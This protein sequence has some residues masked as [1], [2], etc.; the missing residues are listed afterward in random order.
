MGEWRNKSAIII[1]W[2]Y[3]M[4][5]VS[6]IPPGE[7]SPT[8]FVWETGWALGEGLN[9]TITA[10]AGNKTPVIH[11]LANGYWYPLLDKRK[12]LPYQT[13]SVYVF[14]YLF[15]DFLINWGNVASKGWM[16][17]NNEFGKR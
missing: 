15:E 2:I 16:K 5:V 9:S 4:W 10:P 11:L 12:Q 3:C 14:M 1:L 7:L 6:F 17:E 13:L 8:A